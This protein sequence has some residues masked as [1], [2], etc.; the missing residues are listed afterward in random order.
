MKSDIL[1]NNKKLTKQ[2]YFIVWLSILGA[3]PFIFNRLIPIPSLSILCTITFCYFAII[4]YVDKIHLKKLNPKFN[5]IFEIQLIAWLL[6]IVIH[7]DILYIERII[8]MCAIYLMLLFLQNC[9]G[10]ILKFFEK[11]DKFILYVAVGGCISFL[12][13]FIF[14]LPP[15]IS[16]INMDGREA[17]IFFLTSSNYQ[18]GNIIRF[19]GLFDEPGAMAYWGIWTLLFNKLY[20][21][22]L[23]LERLLIFC[24]IFTFSMAYYIQI[25]FYFIFFKLQSIKQ[26]LMVSIT[27]IILLIGAYHV[28]QEYPVLYNLTFNR[29][30]KNENG[31]IKGD[32]RSE[33]AEKAKIQFIK[34]PVIGNGISKMST[35]E[36]MADN[37]YETLAY[38]GIIGTI[39]VYLPFIVLMVIGDK[40]M[41]LSVII[42]F[43]GFLQ[44]PFHHYLLY[45]FIAYGFTYLYLNRNFLNK[46]IMLLSN[47]KS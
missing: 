20:Y 44:R 47:K 6:F 7:Q 4:S 25:V 1:S 15:F 38:D 18:V 19:A 42:L 17:G 41:R 46:N 45:Y 3:Y 11:Y 9:D 8:Y 36:Y 43:I 35:M 24:L 26:V 28:S 29:F 5:L 39:I 22:D 31:E 2:V 10:G 33:L 23:R 21:N 30:Q 40:K 12:L 32:N 34:S 27:G 16:F 13:V 37:P 14:N